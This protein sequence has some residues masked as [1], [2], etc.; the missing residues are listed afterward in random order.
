MKCSR[1]P[2]YQLTVDEQ[3]QEESCKIFGDS[4]DS[5]FQ[6]TDR[7]NRVSGCYIDKHY[8]DKFEE[9]EKSVDS[10][11]DKYFNSIDD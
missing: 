3:W 9:C 5:R 1:C 8:I 11:V 10:L 4:W 2:L 6:Y 7:S